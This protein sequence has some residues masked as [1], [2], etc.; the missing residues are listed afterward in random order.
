M[1]GSVLRN[2]GV[3]TST[4][5]SSQ[6]DGCD[7]QPG[8]ISIIQADLLL[9]AQPKPLFQ[10]LSF[11]LCA[12]PSSDSAT[13]CTCLC[14]HQAAQPQVTA[15]VTIGRADLLG[16]NCTV[17]QLNIIVYCFQNISWL[18]HRL[19]LHCGLWLTI[20]L[21]HWHNAGAI[22]HNDFYCFMCSWGM[23][24]PCMYCIPNRYFYAKIWNLKLIWNVSMQKYIFYWA[25][26]KQSFKSHIYHTCMSLNKNWPPRVDTD[27]VTFIHP[28]QH[29][30]VNNSQCREWEWDLKL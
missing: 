25:I 11:G 20:S 18:L 26:S 23:T 22:E 12:P 6:Q 2:P 1:D 10:M 28:S 16:G 14:T 13:H 27:S 24:P 15:A 7:Q 29:C 4:W 8:W 30:P 5:I 19:H 17:S 21:N 3:S 9:A